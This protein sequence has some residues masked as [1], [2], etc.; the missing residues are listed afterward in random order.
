V[1]MPYGSS[2]TELLVSETAKRRA[3]EALLTGR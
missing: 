1:L 2:G 3:V